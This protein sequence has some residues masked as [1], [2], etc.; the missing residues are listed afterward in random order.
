MMQ[1]PLQRT[2]R[3]EPGEPMS[4]ES[5]VLAGLP[6]SKGAMVWAHIHEHAYD[7]AE[8]RRGAQYVR[9]HAP[10]SRGAGRKYL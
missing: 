5:V 8:S 10:P 9:R 1:E 3:F 2:L 7:A 6:L 4:N